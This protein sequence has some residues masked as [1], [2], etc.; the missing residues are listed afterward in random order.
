MS[1]FYLD[2]ITS[3]ASSSVTGTL[4]PPS[5]MTTR[6]RASSPHCLR[7]SRV[8]PTS[9]S[10]LTGSTPGR[11]SNGYSVTS[12]SRRYLTSL[13]SP[14]TLYFAFHNMLIFLTLHPLV[15]GVRG[16]HPDRPQAPCGRRHLRLQTGES[17][18]SFCSPG[19]SEAYPTR[20]CSGSERWPASLP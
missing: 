16:R 18:S 3:P 7:R 5:S 10:P 1:L 8:S 17:G 15:S 9:P 13:S 19:S 6:S 14:T 20:G 2:R 11:T 4:K 12:F